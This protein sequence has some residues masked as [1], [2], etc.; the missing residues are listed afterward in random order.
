MTAK[1]Y[2]GEVSFDGDRP[3]A[4]TGTASPTRIAAEFSGEDLEWGSVQGS[5]V[6]ERDNTTAPWRGNAT[7]RCSRS[8][9]DRHAFQSRDHRLQSIAVNDDDPDRPLVTGQWIEDGEVT[10]FEV[11]LWPVAE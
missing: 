2:A 8:R 1:R 4:A 6:F 10:L 9:G 7:F 11:E 5:Y 3:F